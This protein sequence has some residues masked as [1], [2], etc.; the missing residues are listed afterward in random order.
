MFDKLKEKFKNFKND[1]KENYKNFKN[2]NQ[3][4]KKD[5]EN[6]SSDRCILRI[7]D[8]QMNM[9]VAT[10]MLIPFMLFCFFSGKVSGGIIFLPFVC[11]VDISGYFG[12][13]SLKKKYKQALLREKQE[14][15]KENQNEK[16]N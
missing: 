4:K 10:I 1:I 13:K 7:Q 5:F 9:A 12:I 14:K 8:V 6:M 15:E 2:Y 11:G 3:M 16:D